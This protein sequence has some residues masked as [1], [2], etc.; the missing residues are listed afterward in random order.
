[1]K[2]KKTYPFSE[3]EAERIQKIFGLSNRQIA[4]WR[5]RN[6]FPKKLYEGTYNLEKIAI[7]E[8]EKLKVLKICDLLSKSHWDCISDFKLYAIEKNESKMYEHELI[9]FKRELTNLTNELKQYRITKNAKHLKSFL[10]N[11]RVQHMKFFYYQ[12]T[13]SKFHSQLIYEA[14]LNQSKI[15]EDYKEAISMMIDIRLEF[16]TF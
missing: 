3:K 10:E 6:S 8:S 7:S 11:K 15:L 4:K 12:N 9:S 13:F 2:T 16:F 14:I 5:F 1:M